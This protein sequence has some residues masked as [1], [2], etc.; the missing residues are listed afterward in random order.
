MVG[1]RP[2]YELHFH[3]SVQGAVVGDYNKVTQIFQGS[4]TRPTSGSL[5]QL[6]PDIADFTG[7][8]EELNSITALLRQ[9]PQSA[10]SVVTGMAG[11]GKSALA[12][13]VAHQLKHDF[14]DAQLYV[15]L[16]GTEGEPLAPLEVLADFLRAWGVDDQSMPESL[17]QRIDL[18]RSLLS[19]K[20]ALVLLDDA[21]D[22]AHV[23]SLLPGSSTCAVL[24]TSRRRLS[25]LEEATILDLAAMTPTEALELLHKQVGVDSTHAE[26]EA[27]KKII[28]LCGR[29]P[30]AIRI[31]GGILGNKPEWQL[32]DYA[33]RLTQEQQRLAQ[34][35]L[36]NLEVRAT[37]ALSYQ[38]LD[39]LSARLF[40]LLGLLSG[41]NI[42]PEVAAAL[43]ESEPATAEKSVKCLV[44]MQLLEPALRGRYRLHDLVRLFAKEQLA[45]EEPT[46][47]RQG[48][49]L[50]A[51][52][53]YLETSEM[54]NLAL[55]P[56]TR[57]QLAKVLVEG[58][59]KSLEA[60][61]QNLFLEALNWFKIERMNLLSS[62]E[63]AYQAQAWEIVAPLARNLVNFFN[64]YAY[65]TDWERTHLLAMEATHKLGDRLGEAQTLINLG[66]VYSLQN[67]WEKAS[68]CYEKSLGIFGELRD[69]AGVAK[70]LGNLANVYSQQGYWGK[71]GECYKQSLVIFG[72]LKDRYGEAQTLANMGIFH[73]QQSHEDKAVALW[74]E[75]L[76]KLPSD[77]PKSKRVVEWLHSI[78]KLTS[79]SVADKGSVPVPQETSAPPQRR[80]LYMIGGIVLAIAIALFLLFLIQ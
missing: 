73:I 33:F 68:D 30:L 25:E 63:W 62:V 39:A 80:S 50:R 17:T 69:N 72:E 28:D 9:A 32:E 16:R 59:D 6:P 55:N 79:V 67:N 19:G 14:P 58:K 26:R 37:L 20:R 71:A 36:S 4:L 35:R 41:A 15:N 38:K 40:R 56:E 29:L 31:T 75:A 61:E 27:A 18:Y 47:A 70:S 21:H 3:A 54:M 1:D 13:H 12:I 65:R 76:T 78:S 5:H 44:D 60:T 7:R 77:L 23:R 10:I 11:V 48:A 49:R 34:Q 46:E 45:Q 42:T 57:R 2:R 22:E 8:Q 74:Q 64:T 66:N 51:A 43:L 24:V 52:S 53:W